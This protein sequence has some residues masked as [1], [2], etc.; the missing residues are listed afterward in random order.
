VNAFEIFLRDTVV[1]LI[2]ESLRTAAPARLEFS[3]ARAG[4]AMKP[5]PPRAQRHDHHNNP[6]PRRARRSRGCP[7]LK[8]TGADGRPRAILFGY[9]CHNTTLSG[10][11][12]ERRLRGP[13]AA[14]PRSELSGRDRAVS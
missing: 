12:G 4:F 13:R 14:F 10:E 8:V 3:S 1:A 9:A 5:P 6:Y 7:V 2:G 11:Q